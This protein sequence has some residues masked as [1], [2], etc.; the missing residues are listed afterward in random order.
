MIFDLSQ[1]Q[2]TVLNDTRPMPALLVQ[3]A[4]MPDGSRLDDCLVATRKQD[5]EIELWKQTVHVYSDPD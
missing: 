4:M 5:C 3:N 1:D 2:G